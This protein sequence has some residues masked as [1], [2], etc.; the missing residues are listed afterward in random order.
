[1]ASA[2]TVSPDNSVSASPLPGWIAIPAVAG[3]VAGVVEALEFLVVHPLKWNVRVVDVTSEILW[4][5]PAV[6]LFVF[7]WVGAVLA[8]LGRLV[9]WFR[10]TRVIAF[11]C[12]LLTFNL[13]FGV[14]AVE[15]IALYSIVLLACG[16]AVQTARWAGRRRDAL[17]SWCRKRL[18]AALAL[19]AILVVSVPASLAMKEAMAVSQLPALPSGTPSVLIL[20]LDTV[21]ADHLSAYGYQRPTSPNL[22]RVA[23]E[24]VLF[25]RAIAAGPYTL[26]GHIALLT[27]LY[28]YQNRV[29]D[30]DTAPY[31]ELRTLSHELSA[32]G[33]RTGGFSANL[34]WFT[35]AARFNSGFL[36]FE[37][38]FQ[39][40]ADMLYRTVLGRSV[41]KLAMR[42]LGFEDI[43]ARRRASDMNH[44]VL[45]WIGADP[46]PFFAVVNYMDA[47]DPYMPSEPHRTRF[48]KTPNPG[49]ILNWRVGRRVVNLTEAQ[50]EAEVAAYDGALS[51]L[52]EQ[53]GSLLA[54]LSE[55][56]RLD[57]TIVIVT[58]D[59]GEMFGEHRL[60]LHANSVYRGVIHV[61]LIIRWPGRVPA[62]LRISQPASQTWVPATV[63]DLVSDTPPGFPGNSLAS[64]WTEPG[65]ER[66]WPAPLSHVPHQ[67]WRPK[68]FPNSSGSVSSMVTPQ[69]HFIQH[70][71][72]APELYD[73]QTD[74]TQSRNLARDPS[75]ATVVGELQAALRANIAALRPFSAATPLE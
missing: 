48:S 42:R 2:V 67:P 66:R 13:W 19:V 61:P 46:R 21:R 57:N 14:I 16:L 20:V 47:H 68:H 44:S 12:A 36:H 69:W 4:I 22:E 3:V 64:A 15:H 50:R 70:Q 45:R 52:D 75:L 35:R 73:W 24:G 37:D 41:E 51:Y 74:P 55:R 71:S 17:E 29:H 56:R 28:P 54:S 8:M 10:D 33:Y 60:F 1:M 43:P 9:P 30:R 31:S 26:P 72:R 58:S 5:A 6:N 18:P 65:S 53:I 27:G 40:P 11:V 7:L 39:S 63:M 25:E 34:F 23:R 32:R 62:G 38:Y 49:G 59:H